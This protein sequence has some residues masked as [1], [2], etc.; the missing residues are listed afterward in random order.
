MMKDWGKHWA[1]LKARLHQQEFFVPAL[2]LE[3]APYLAQRDDQAIHHLSRYHWAA[4]VIARAGKWRV[5]DIACGAGYGS[6][7]LA[8]HQPKARVRG[9]DYDPRAIAY[10]CQHYQQPQLSYQ[11]GDLVRWQSSDGASLGRA[12]CVVCFDTLEHLLHREIAL[13]NIA[14]NLGPAGMLL[15]STPCRNQSVLNPGWEHH[16]IEYSPED[17]EN[18]LRRFFKRVLRPDRDA[19]FPY[20]AFWHEQVNAQRLIYSL[21]GNPLVCLE[22]IQYR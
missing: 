13:I 5:L 11:T 3:L 6:Y 21:R 17:L 20:L 7:L 2:G 22:P 14:E 12:S 4:E 8:S 1:A 18:L 15:L 10:A 19:D 9:V 16:K